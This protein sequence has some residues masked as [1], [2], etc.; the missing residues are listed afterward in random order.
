M[1]RSGLSGLGLHALD[2]VSGHRSSQ[3]AHAA[4]R[5]GRIAAS[6]R[7][8][9]GP[10]SPLSRRSSCSSLD[11][12]VLLWLPSVRASPARASGAG[13]RSF[14]QSAGSAA[15][16]R[17]PA[18]LHGESRRR[19][20]SDRQSSQYSEAQLILTHLPVATSC[21]M[22]PLTLTFLFYF[23]HGTRRTQI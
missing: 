6:R 13:E 19:L 11:A 5:P 18:I 10:H 15:R 3:G 1:R 22:Y 12:V 9:L 7:G 2:Q 16:G 21:P 17:W 23:G 8:P 14:R 4:L 20:A